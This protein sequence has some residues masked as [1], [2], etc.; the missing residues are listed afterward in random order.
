VTRE[1]SRGLLADFGSW[2]RY[3]WLAVTLA[4]AIAGTNAYLWTTEQEPPFLLVAGS[5]L[6]GLVVFCTRFWKPVLYLFALVHLGGLFVL[7]ALEGAPFRT[8]GLI[9]GGLSLALAAVA[10]YLFVESE[11]GGH[12]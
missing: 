7:W 12:T 8:A 2:T 11:T 5:F 4:L 9:N 10:M 1:R 6:A 3:H